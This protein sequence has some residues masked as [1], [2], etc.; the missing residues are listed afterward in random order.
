MAGYFLKIDGIAGESQDDR[1]KDEIEV[2]SFSWGETFQPSA[3]GIAGAGK[4]HVQDFHITKQIDKASPLLLLAAASG[5]HFQSAVL[6][7]QR[8]GK[9]PQD[10]F[11]ITLSE[12]MVSSYQI[13]ARA[14]QPSPSEQVSFSF[15]RI[16][17]VYSPQLAD[18]TAGTPVNAGWDITANRKI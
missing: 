8:P 15:G 11:T 16:E 18:G 17:I 1:H 12:L 5:E 3:P 2:D 9:E 14:E 4:V 10:Y 6:T 13:E 7:A